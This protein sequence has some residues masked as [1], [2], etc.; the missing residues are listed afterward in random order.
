ML[1][2][3]GDGCQSVASA[4]CKHSGEGRS[5]LTVSCA[6]AGHLVSQTKSHHFLEPHSSASKLCHALT[7]AHP[8]RPCRPLADSQWFV[9]TFLCHHQMEDR[10]CKRSESL[11]VLQFAGN[12]AIDSVRQE[13]FR[14]DFRSRIPVSD[15]WP[16]PRRRAPQLDY[17]AVRIEHDAVIMQ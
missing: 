14:R 10:R 17:R 1:W 5:T 7:R 9:A 11:V 4:E 13:S 15:E 2:I 8:C 12:L 3:W 16:A 6:A